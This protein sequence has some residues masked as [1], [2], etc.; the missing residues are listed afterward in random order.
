MQVE[1]ARLE[2]AN[3]SNVAGGEL[4]DNLLY[5]PRL[6]DFQAKVGEFAPQPLSLPRIGDEHRVLYHCVIRVGQKLP[7]PHNFLLFP[8]RHLGDNGNLACAIG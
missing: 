6:G 3:Y 8:V 4:A 5:P 7:H 2:N 1:L